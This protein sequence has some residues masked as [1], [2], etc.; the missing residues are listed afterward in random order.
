VP[1]FISSAICPPEVRKSL[2]EICVQ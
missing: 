1:L 2:K